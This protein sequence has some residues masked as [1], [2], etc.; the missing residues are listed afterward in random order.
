METGSIC[1]VVRIDN[2]TMRKM[3]IDNTEGIS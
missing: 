3:A 2:A 1:S